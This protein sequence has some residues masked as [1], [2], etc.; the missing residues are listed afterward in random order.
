MKAN[1]SIT[2]DTGA[3]GAEDALGYTPLTLGDIKAVMERADELIGDDVLADD[4]DERYEFEACEDPEGTAFVQYPARTEWDAYAF[5]GAVGG[6]AVAEGLFAE[7]TTEWREGIEVKVDGE[8]KPRRLVSVFLAHRD[9]MDAKE[10]ADGAANDTAK[11]AAAK[12][13]GGAE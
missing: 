4:V 8:D 1:I 2:I 3:D 10:A 5:V 7:V 13:E 6:A 12:K 11:G 9:Y